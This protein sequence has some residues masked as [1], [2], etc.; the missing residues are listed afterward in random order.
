MTRPFIVK[1]RGIYLV[2]YSHETKAKEFQSLKEAREFLDE[3]AKEGCSG[4]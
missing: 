3:L 4:G 1:D 2:L